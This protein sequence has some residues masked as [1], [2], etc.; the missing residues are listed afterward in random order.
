MTRIS[1]LGPLAIDGHR[2]NA[3]RRERQLLTLLAL[4]A[5]APVSMPRIV[6]ALWGD[7]PPANATNAVQASVSRVRR[8]MD[9]VAV[10]HT[11]AGYRLIVTSEELDVVEMER[12]VS[13][14]RSHTEAALRL[15]LADRALSLVR[16]EP[17]Q[18]L[19]E[20]LPAERTRLEE[21]ILGAHEIRADALV[22]TGRAGEAVVAL[23]QL[24]QEHPL[25]ERL[26]AQLVEALYAD[27]RQGEA[28]R[29][30]QRAANMLAEE[31]GVEPGP[32]LR[33]AEERVLMQDP[34]LL[35]APRGWSAGGL[36]PLRTEVFGRADAVRRVLGSLETR[37]LVTLTGP[38]GVGKTTVALL[39]GTTS[40]RPAWFIDLTG[41]SD[42]SS[43]EQLM[44]SSFSDARS[45]VGTPLDRAVSFLAGRPTLLI[46]DNCEHLVEVAA[47]IVRELLDRLPELAV[48]AT[49]RQPL[50][51]AEE[52]M[53][54]LDPLD[55]TGP[56][57]AAVS[58]FL[59]RARAVRADSV[60]PD[61]LQMV[62]DICDRV[63]GL[64][65]AVVLA[66]SAVSI[67][68]VHDMYR[69][70]EA[71]AHIPALPRRDRPP[72]HDTVDATIDWSVDQLDSDAR[73]LFERMSIFDT[74]PTLDA[75]VSVCGFDPLNSTSAVDAI[76][77]LVT[78]S[79]VT[80]DGGRYWMLSV[81]RNN[82]ER[83]RGDQEELA[84]R[85]VEFHADF[86]RNVQPRIL[87]GPDQAGLLDTI[88][89]TR[90]DLEAALRL[91][92]EIAPNRAAEIAAVL[93]WASTIRLSDD[94]TLELVESVLASLDLEVTEA[95]VTAE[96]GLALSEAVGERRRTDAAVG[97][98]HTI[99]R[100]ERLGMRRETGLGYGVMA[101]LQ[102][103]DLAHAAQLVAK[104]T[105]VI[106][107]GDDWGTG[108]MAL[109]EANVAGYTSGVGDA[110]EAARRAVDLLGRSQDHWR[111]ATA[112]SVLGTLN[113]MCGEYEAADE[114]YREV[115]RISDQMEL[116]Y[117]GSLA[118]SQLA[119]SA[120]LAGRSSQ[121]LE[122]AQ[123]AVAYAD[124][125]G[126]GGAR[127][128][129]LNTL[130]R[131]LHVTNWLVEARS[132]HEE[133]LNIYRMLDAWA[134]VAHT[135]D[136]LGLVESSA[137]NGEG[138]EALHREAL[139]INEESGDPL[140][141]AF[142]LEGLALAMSLTDRGRDAARLLGASDR[143]RRALGVPLVGGER[144]HVARA[145]A[146]ARESGVPFEQHFADGARAEDWRSVVPDISP[147]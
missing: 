108:I 140:S 86:A 13:A 132:A 126:G 51:L 53:F 70:L 137:G 10:E 62:I 76:S 90:Q 102:T 111:Q 41:A 23:E 118:R 141:V 39:A 12:L 81:V 50:G 54:T 94:S 28:L 6:D 43:A 14:A 11:G 47:E 42:R 72:R 104:G 34:T 84:R 58:L 139:A 52:Q 5:G 134:G 40:D 21:L 121:A 95:S 87:A 17:L 107:E 46:V 1:L 66:A 2:V 7:D 135:L 9:T 146:L 100:A 113:L 114:A 105:A 73:T 110:I 67:M 143:L 82:A 69:R 64:P 93:V 60:G 27:G 4:A 68:S 55:T 48:V 91:A 89:A 101:L 8:A 65:L 49:S 98:A 129:A 97:L 127:A 138:A 117:D 24:L 128:N 32:G 37:R 16:G 18:D 26:W 130:G 22:T 3:G 109:I 45:D 133:A 119:N 59:D 38:G 147:T 79:L 33:A 25:R 15:E 103:D 125:L 96:L 78:G 75:V 116:Q 29:A 56:S 85:Y 124:R 31:L 144:R 74:P 80:L 44:S 83:R 136:N 77:Q 88:D 131:V 115:V 19:A 57:A 20:Q 36:P 142:T 112:L 61:D 92:S 30:Y 106:E 122:L 123:A 145:E 99:E 71:G 63:D 120:M 35:P